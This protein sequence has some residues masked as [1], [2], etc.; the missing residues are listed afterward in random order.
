[1]NVDELV[2]DSLREQAAEQPPAAP[3]FADRVLAVRRRR[4]TRTLA[5]VAAAT[6][7]VVA[8]AVAVPLL[9]SGK[10]DVRPAS[11]MNQSDIIAH[12]DQS[13]PRDLI[14]AGDV[15]LA[16]YYTCEDRQAAEGRRRHRAH[17]LA[18]RPED[19]QVREG[20]QVVRSST[21]PPACG[22]PPS[23]RRTCPPSGSGCSTCS[24][25]RS[26]AG[27]RSTGA[28]AGVAFSPDGSKLVATTYSKNPDLRLQAGPRQRRR[29]Q[30]ERLHAGLVRVEPDRLLRR[31]RGLRQGRL[32][33]GHRDEPDEMGGRQRPPGLRLQPRRQAGLR[34]A[35]R[36]SR[37]TQYYDLD[38]RRGRQRRRTR[39]TCTWYVEARLSP[40]GKL[41]AGGFA[42]E[43]QGRPP[44]RSSTPAPASGSPRSADSSCS[45]GSTTSGSSPGT[46][47]PGSATS[48]ATSSCS[49]PS[50]ATRSYR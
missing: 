45:P 20:H 10:D 42:G 30:E 25:A 12:P 7:A 43:R 49:S 22:P 3:G 39:S 21:S 6:A 17:L 1:M 46:R 8:V 47:G 26:S 9:D 13:P 29:R 34:R 24:P 32:E 4:R 28:S 44:P 35:E 14:A 16:A 48:S 18:P 27:S 50:A 2:R 40:D 5:S 19:R 23:W 31:R 36:R 38:G 11:E 37:T 41:A 15:A 33:R